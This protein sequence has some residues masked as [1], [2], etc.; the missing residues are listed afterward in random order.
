MPKVSV[1]LSSYNHGK[2]IAASIESVLNQTFSDFE[3][4]IFDDGSS[5]NSQELSVHSATTELNFSCTK[6]IA[7][8]ITQRKRH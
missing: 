3:L 8:H 1:I 2:Y 5:D 6:K 4:L 7:A